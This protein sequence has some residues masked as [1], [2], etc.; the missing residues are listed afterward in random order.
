MSGNATNTHIWD[1]ADVYIAPEGTEGPTDLTTAWAAD[2]HAAGLLDGDEGFTESRSEDTSDKYAWGGLLYRHT[3]SHHKR[4]IKFVALE[5]NDVVFG[6]REPG[7]TR[8]TASGVRTSVI[9]VPSDH[10]FAIG[11][12][13]HDG[14]RVRRRIA[15]AASVTDLGDIKDSESDPTV[16]E[17]T[18]V[19][20]PDADGT[21]WTDIETDPAG[22]GS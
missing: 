22:S 5:D 6:L 3:R 8:T 7:S 13:T 20:Y 9:K 14:D 16:Y 12:E 10:R 15:S 18:V 1:N 17:F 21:L 11:F 4:T 19:I 2:W